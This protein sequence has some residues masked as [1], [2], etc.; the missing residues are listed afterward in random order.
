MELKE[1]QQGVLSKLDRYLTGLQEQR[2][3][4]EEFVEFQQSKGKTGTLGDYCRET[5]DGNPPEKQR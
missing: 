4:A 5:W 2:E 3:E 1:Y